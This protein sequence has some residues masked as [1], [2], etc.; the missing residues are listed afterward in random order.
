MY[1]SVG[2]WPMVTRRRQGV[3]AQDQRGYRNRAHPSDV[4]S[5]RLILLRA[6]SRKEE[7]ASSAREYMRRISSQL[8]SAVPGG[9]VTARVV[10]ADAP[11]AI[12]NAAKDFEVDVI[13]MS[14]RGHAGLARA[15]LGSTATSTLQQAPVPL[16]VLGPHALHEPSS[17]QIHLRA[18]VRTLDD[19]LVGEVH[20]V[21]IDLDQRALVSVVVLGRGPLGRDVLVPVDFIETLDKDQLVLRLCREELDQL[22]EFTYNEFVTPPPTWTLLVPRIVGPAWIAATQRKRIGSHQQDITPGSHVLAVDGD[23]GPVDRVEVDRTGELE[24]F[25]VRGNTLFATDMRIAVEWIQET[26][27]QGNL[28]IDGTKADIEAYLGH[29]SRIR[30]HG[31]PSLPGVP[32]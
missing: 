18:P 29:E 5:T 20:R 8:E 7:D 22:P 27:I 23:I 24:A 21:V 9:E 14:T 25:W 31:P 11:K 26:D 6:T 15:V 17:E 2:N 4:L 10:S 13:V 16:I 3:T 30:L 19:E 32:H 1:T 28:R 12:L